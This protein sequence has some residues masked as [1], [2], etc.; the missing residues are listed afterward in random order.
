MN[1]TLLTLATNCSEFWNTQASKTQLI[2]GT[3][4]LN[5]SIS[6]QTILLVNEKAKGGRGDRGGHILGGGSDAY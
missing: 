4:I 6:N 3:K 2:E 1:F 5:W